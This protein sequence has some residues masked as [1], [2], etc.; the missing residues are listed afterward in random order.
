MKLIQKVTA[1]L[2]DNYTTHI[3]LIENVTFGV[4][5]V[6]CNYIKLG[7]FEGFLFNYKQTTSVTE[8]AD[9]ELHGLNFNANDE[10]IEIEISY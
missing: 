9:L 7:S 5:E 10:F 1:G 3:S 6:V 2:A 8:I 4:A